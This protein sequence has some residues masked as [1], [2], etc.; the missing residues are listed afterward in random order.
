MGLEREEGDSG[1]RLKIERANLKA[2]NEN[3]ERLNKWER[4]FTA[5]I[6]IRIS[7]GGSLSQSQFN[8]LAE[9]ADKARKESMR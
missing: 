3:L 9:I 8:R 5:S 7:Y 1:M 2:C 6:E 4:E